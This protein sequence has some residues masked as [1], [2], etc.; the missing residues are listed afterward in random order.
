MER[1]QDICYTEIEKT[2]AYI[3]DKVEMKVRVEE[4][5]EVVI[6]DLDGISFI[7]KAVAP[8]IK[9]FSGHANYKRWNQQFDL[10]NWHFFMAFDG[11][12]PVGGAVLCCHCAELHMLEGRED[13]GILWDIRVDSAYKRRGVGGK[14]FD[15]VKTKAKELGLCQLKI[16]CQNNNVPAAA[17]YFKQGAHLGA[18]NRYAYAYYGDAD[19]AEEVQLLLY[20]DLDKEHKALLDR[21]EYLKCM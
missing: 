16:E 12:K 3:Y 4:I 13:L 5:Y 18:V 21:E 8:Y 11:E 15:M 1:G 2:D 10:S 14:L 19:E 7:K 6:K 20:L 9:D 17:F